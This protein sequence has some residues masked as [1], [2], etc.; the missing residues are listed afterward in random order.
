MNE[1]SAWMGASRWEGRRAAQCVNNGSHEK[2]QKQV[3]HVQ[4]TMLGSNRNSYLGTVL[5]HRGY[6]L[7]RYY[8][9]RPP[10]FNFLSW[11]KVFNSHLM[12][13]NQGAYRIFHPEGSIPSLQ[14]PAGRNLTGRMTSS[15]S[16]QRCQHRESYRFFHPEGSS[17]GIN[18]TRCMTSLGSKSLT[19][20]G[21]AAE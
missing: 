12:R 17:P 2:K 1:Y 4:T 3:I 8:P 15:L 20:T 18:L 7:A 19:A 11:S 13:H 9:N 5:S 10:H 14:S 21:Q 6:L 16:N